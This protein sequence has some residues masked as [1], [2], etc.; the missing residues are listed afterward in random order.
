MST[1]SMK[2]LQKKRYQICHKNIKM[3]KSNEQHQQ[4]DK[5]K[6]MVWLAME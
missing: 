4:K 5:S 2:R 1:I 6:V 3:N